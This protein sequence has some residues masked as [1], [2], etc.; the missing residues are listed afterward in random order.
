MLNYLLY[1]FIF[2]YLIPLLSHTVDMMIAVF[3]PLIK[4]D[5]V[6][7]VIQ[8]SDKELNSQK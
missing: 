8:E 3:Y 1:T 6:R 4:T 7:K 5:I 2:Q